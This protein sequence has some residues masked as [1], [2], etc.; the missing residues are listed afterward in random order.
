M[1]THD[2][3][4]NLQPFQTLEPDLYADDADGTT[5]DTYG[6]ESVMFF[7]AEG[8]LTDGTHVVTFQESDDDMTWTDIDA[9]DMDGFTNDITVTGNDQHTR[10][11]YGTSQYVRAITVVTGSPGTG[12]EYAVSVLLNTLRHSRN[13]E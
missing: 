5:I 12:A 8:D 1:A 13:E 10:G 4:Y 6:Y 9:S 3:F 7:L 2:L 11:Y